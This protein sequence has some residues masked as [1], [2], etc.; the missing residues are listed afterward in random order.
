M[1]EEK[2]MAENAVA[3]EDQAEG[4]STRERL[5]FLPGGME[6]PRRYCR[7]CRH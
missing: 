1:T 6:C 4:I 2:A 3:D 7:H 5:L